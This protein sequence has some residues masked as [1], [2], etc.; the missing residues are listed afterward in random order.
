MILSRRPLKTLEA[1]WRRRWAKQKDRGHREVAIAALLENNSE[2]CPTCNQTVMSGETSSENPLFIDE[3]GDVR[4]RL[5]SFVHA[6][7]V[8]NRWLGLC[9]RIL[10]RPNATA[11]ESLPCSYGVGARSSFSP[12][13]AISMIDLASWLGV[14]RAFGMGHSSPGMRS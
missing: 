9:S 8:V 14:P 7:T 11:A 4:S 1:A 3:F 12:V 10:A 5:P 6:I 2:T 13:V